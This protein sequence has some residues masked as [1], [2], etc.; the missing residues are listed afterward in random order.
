MSA[1]CPHKASFES[2]PG[3]VFLDTNVV[4]F[5]LD[6]GEQIHDVVPLPR[7]LSERAS[8]DIEALHNLFLT[9]QRA[10][11]QLVVSPSTYDEV[12]RTN[13]RRRR[14][15]LESWFGEILCCWTEIAERD[16]EILSREEAL[17]L[18]RRTLTSGVLELLPDTN[19]RILICDAIAYNCDLFCTRDWSTILRHRDRLPVLSVE[20]V[21]L[22]E[23]W[24][25]IVPWAGLWD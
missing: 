20:I 3:R 12:V 1:A 9:G 15:A 17:N 24:S 5:I 10:C 7:N 18:N 11:W 25:R 14:K 19:D 23:W 8:N 21:T 6:Y 13:N 22:T 4:N 2:I 16:P